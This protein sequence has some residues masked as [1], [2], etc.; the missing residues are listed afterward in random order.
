M[1]FEFFFDRVILEETN[2]RIQK[3]LDPKSHFGC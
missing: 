2:I 1:W 3:V